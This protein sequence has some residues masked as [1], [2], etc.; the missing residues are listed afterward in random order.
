MIKLEMEMGYFSKLRP[1]EMVE[2]TKA[3][4][5]WEDLVI[6]EEVM[7]DSPELMEPEYDDITALWCQIQ[8]AEGQAEEGLSPHHSWEALQLTALA[9]TSKFLLDKLPND[10]RVTRFKKVVGLTPLEFLEQQGFV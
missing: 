5:L 6:P 1:L 9:A 4:R 3:V 8:P 7:P 2:A 10:I